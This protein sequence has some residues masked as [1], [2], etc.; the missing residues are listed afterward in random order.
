MPMGT[1]VHASLPEELRQTF[2]N[3]ENVKILYGMTETMLMAAYNEPTAL[4]I[5]D[6]GKTG[7]C[8]QLITITYMSIFCIHL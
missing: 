7:F 8:F 1:T 3:F 2:V 5:A 6:A 4:G